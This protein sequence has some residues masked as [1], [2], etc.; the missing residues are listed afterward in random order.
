MDECEQLCNRLAIMANGSFKCIGHVPDLKQ[1]Y[2]TG[3]TIKV[4]LKIPY[5]EQSVRIV[6]RQIAELF[7]ES[8]LRENHAGMLTYLIKSTA[9]IKWSQVFERTHRLSFSTS[10]IIE[11]YS[12]NESTLEDIFLKV[13]SDRDSLQAATATTPTDER[14]IDV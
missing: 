13:D 2:G 9:T 6:T 7:E 8:E 3:F 5:N 14:I 4:K 10:E 11:D 1:R 12:V